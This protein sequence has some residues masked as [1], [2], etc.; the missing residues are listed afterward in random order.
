MVPGG[1]IQAIL[2]PARVSNPPPVPCDRGYA[3]HKV[4][5]RVTWRRPQRP[6][7]IDAQPGS[8]VLTW[9][10]GLPVTEE[11]AQFVTKLLLAERRRRGSRAL[12]CSGRP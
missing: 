8:H 3:F 10:V 7:E 2:R 1:W 5:M 11:L 4:A 6:D 9:R 12:T